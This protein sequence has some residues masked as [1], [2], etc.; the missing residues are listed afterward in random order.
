M[1][2]RASVSSS[3]METRA[4]RASVGASCPLHLTPIIT[5]V[6]SYVGCGEHYFIAPVCKRWLKHYR[7]LPTIRVPTADC[8]SKYIACDAYTTL[9]KAACASQSRLKDAHYCCELLSLNNPQGRL[10]LRTAGRYADTAALQLLH[11]EYA[12]PWSVFVAKGAAESGSYDKLLWLCTERGCQL[13]H[14]ASFY[15]AKSGSV[16]MLQW[17]RARGVDFSTNTTLSAVKAGQLQAMQ[18]LRSVRCPWNRFLYGAAAEAGNVEMLQWLE[19]HHCPWDSTAL[20]DTAA[21]TK[22]ALEVAAKTAGGWEQC[23]AAAA[24]GISAMHWLYQQVQRLL[25]ALF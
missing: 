18:Y 3:S 2:T 13:P 7:Q 21:F 15:A 19:E 11:D 1:R 6:L 4:K 14:D 17:M 12:M 23:E 20:R 5:L 22:Q 16:P 9:L 24:A 25:T 10:M 8:G